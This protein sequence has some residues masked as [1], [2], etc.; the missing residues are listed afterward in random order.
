MNIALRNDF[1]QNSDGQES[2]EGT[3]QSSN[4]ASLENDGMTLQPLDTATRANDGITPQSSDAATLASDESTP[5]KI[6]VPKSFFENLAKINQEES[7]RQAIEKRKRFDSVPGTLTFDA[8]IPGNHRKLYEPVV[9]TKKRRNKE[10]KRQNKENKR[11]SD[12]DY[13]QHDKIVNVL[14]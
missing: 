12:P 3:L 2:M 6:K 8:K 11:S 10:N 7:A 9:I 13:R 4:D 14:R 1:I 5:L